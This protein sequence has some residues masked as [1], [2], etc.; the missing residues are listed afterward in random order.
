M[1]SD[2]IDKIIFEQSCRYM[3]GMTSEGKVEVW[4][5][6]TKDAKFH[7]SL[8]FD[9]VTQI[10]SNPLKENQFFVLMNSLDGKTSSDAAEKETKQDSVLLFQFSRP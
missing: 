4:K 7:W 3:A 1:N 2:K 5:L 8:N 10:E 6:K 9:S